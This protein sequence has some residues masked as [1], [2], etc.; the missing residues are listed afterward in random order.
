MS[1]VL[2]LFLDQSVIFYSGVKYFHVHVTHFFLAVIKISVSLTVLPWLRFKSVNLPKNFRVHLEINSMDL[3]RY[4]RFANWK[5][6]HLDIIKSTFSFSES[7]LSLFF[8][9]L[10]MI[11]HVQ[12]VLL[13]KV[14]LNN[15]THKLKHYFC[16]LLLCAVLHLWAS[17]QPLTKQHITLGWSL[18]TFALTR[19]LWK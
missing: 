14:T 12:H 13:V 9:T 11:T 7:T 6:S 18:F 4:I 8:L 16:V 10:S 5:I 3:W 19:K 15:M 2:L 17:T 1:K